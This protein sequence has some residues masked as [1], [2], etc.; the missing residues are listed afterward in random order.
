MHLV[1]K[2]NKYKISI[3]IVYI[4]MKI[5]RSKI[6]SVEDWT[7]AINYYRNLP[8]IRLNTESSEQIYTRTLCI[9][10]NMDPLVTIENIVQCSE[11]VE[12]F[13]VKVISGAQHFPHQQKPEAVNKAILKFFMG[14]LYL[15]L[16]KFHTFI[17]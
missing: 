1:E 15:L 11:Y 13:T 16:Q 9:I 12:N 17:L 7:G 4:H 5:N 2:V 3:S 6:V 10:G 14:M 8:F